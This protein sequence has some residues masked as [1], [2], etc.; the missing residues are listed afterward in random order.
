MVRRKQKVADNGQVSIEEKIGR[1]IA[2][3]LIKEMDPEEAAVRLSA[4]G[5][6][7]QEISNMLLVNK[8]YVNV[9]KSRW[10]K[11]VK[12]KILQSRPS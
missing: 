3:L 9:A 2:M 8:N 7:A 4:I 5:Y 10:K 1:A 11:R 6:T 12:S